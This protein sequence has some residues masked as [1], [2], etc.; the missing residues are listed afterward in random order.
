V[1]TTVCERCKGF[2]TVCSKCGAARQRRTPKNNYG[3][4]CCYGA[5]VLPCPAHT[6]SIGKCDCCPKTHQERVGT[7]VQ[8]PGSQFVSIPDPADLSKMKSL[9]VCHECHEAFKVALSVAL[10]AVFAARAA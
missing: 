1:S 5:R 2:G 6:P 9:L 3:R 10:D 8:I 7:F 4:K